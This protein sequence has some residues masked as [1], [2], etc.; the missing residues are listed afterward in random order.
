MP[1]PVLVTVPPATIIGTI[2][3]TLVPA[4]SVMIRMLP[5][6]VTASGRHFGVA[7]TII[8][9]IM[10]TLVP[11]GSVMIRLLPAAPAGLP[12]PPVTASA[13]HFRVAIVPG[14][15][16]CPAVLILAL[17]RVVSFV[18]LIFVVAG[19]VSFVRLIFVVA[20]V[21]FVR[22]VPI[23]VRA[24][25]WAL[26]AQCVPIIEGLQR[27]NRLVVFDSAHFGIQHL[28]RDRHFGL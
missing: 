14:A 10:V 12:V 17:V 5:V 20:F 28:D 23:I 6:P 4:G 27:W 11:A 8:G 7:I 21:A 18:R 19:F 16:G 1:M 13:G 3:V 2:M 25:I 15:H 24:G 26:L 9:T 22:F